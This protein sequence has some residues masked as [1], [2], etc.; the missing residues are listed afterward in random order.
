MRSVTDKIICSP[1]V[2][3][4]L[5]SLGMKTSRELELCVYCPEDSVTYFNKKEQMRTFYFKNM[6][7]VGKKSDYVYTFTRKTSSKKLKAIAKLLGL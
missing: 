5:S 2:F 1:K 3:K 4:T 6:E 7:L